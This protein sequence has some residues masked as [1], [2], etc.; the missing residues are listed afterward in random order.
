MFPGLNVL[1]NKKSNIKSLKYLSV[2]Y[3]FGHQ[4]L[5]HIFWSDC[6][7]LHNVYYLSATLSVS[8]IKNYM[9]LY[10]WLRKLRSYVYSVSLFRKATL[11]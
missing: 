8:S 10:N 3:L 4:F 9:S 7:L 1:F 6:Q 5:S 2:A 11:F